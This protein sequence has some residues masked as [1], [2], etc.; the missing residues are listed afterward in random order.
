MAVAVLQAAAQEGDTL[1]PF[2]ETLTRIG[3]RFPD[4]RAC[5]PDRDLVRGQAKFYQEVLDFPAE[6]DSPTM[7]LKVLAE[8]K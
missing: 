8:R 4:R 6:N 5:R 7:A 1:L 3:K 2:S